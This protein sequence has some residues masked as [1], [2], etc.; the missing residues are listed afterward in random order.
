MEA[1]LIGGI[2]FT[3]IPRVLNSVIGSEKLKSHSKEKRRLQQNLQEL[4][5][6]SPQNA[7]SSLTRGFQEKLS[8]MYRATTD[9]AE[10]F[11][12][13]ESTLGK[14]SNFGQAKQQYRMRIGIC[15]RYRLK[16]VG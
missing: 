2:N 12:N 6:T 5:T 15:F 1:G 14:K 9:L 11:R 13:C 10:I 7:Y 16:W 8:F 4:T 3:D